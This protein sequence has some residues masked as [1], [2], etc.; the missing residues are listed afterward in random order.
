M[1]NGI[2]FCKLFIYRYLM[3]GVDKLDSVLLAIVGGKRTVDDIMISCGITEKEFKSIRVDLIKDG[4]AYND[5]NYGYLGLSPTPK[6]ETF[7]EYGG[8][9][10]V[11]KQKILER[12]AAYVGCITGIISLIW[13]ILS[14]FFE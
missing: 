5:N 9:A 8:Y 4:Y 6:G 13:N 7:I 2:L 14:S 1:F 12:W 11:N 3:N 10:S